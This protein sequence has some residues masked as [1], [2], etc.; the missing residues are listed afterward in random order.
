MRELFTYGIASLLIFT[1]FTSSV[2]A[3]TVVRTGDAVS[4]ADDQEIEGDFYSA[5]AKVNLSGS[6]TEDMIS[7]A[8]RITI[9]GSIGDNAWLMGDKVDVHGTVGDDLR[10]FGREVIIAEPVN[11]DLF[12]VGGSVTILSTASITGDALLYAEEVAV[13]GSVGGD[14][15]G[16]VENLRIDTNVAGDVDVSVGQLTLGERTVVEGTVKYT[17]L[18]V[19]IQS[20]EAT[21]SGEV[22]RSDPVLP[23]TQD[24]VRSALVP[25]LILLFSVLAWHLISRRTLQGVVSRALTVSPRPVLV[26]VIAVLFTPILIAVLIVSMIGMLA[27][28]ALLFAYLT[29][30]LLSFIAIPAV[31]GQFLMKI[32][33]RPDAGLSIISIIVGVAASVAFALLP[34]IGQIALSVVFLVALGSLVDSFIRPT[35]ATTVQQ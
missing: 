16:S 23:G 24:N 15:L 19:L 6:V 4:V 14:V 27:G 20:L 17:S 11:G 18:N 29:L 7:A 5:A 8:G 3:R 30:A 9:N 31:L 13:E 28:F 32:L 22:V 25:V 34:V 1:F 21:I 33:N 10:V 12:V 35:K 26:G 2:E